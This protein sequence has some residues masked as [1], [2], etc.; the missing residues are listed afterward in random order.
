MDLTNVK[1]IQILKN[2]SKTSL[3]KISNDVNLS[4]PSVRE[5]ILYKLFLII[6]SIKTS[7]SNPSKV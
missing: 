2:D 4:T 7:I 5:R 1:I 6:I 3:N